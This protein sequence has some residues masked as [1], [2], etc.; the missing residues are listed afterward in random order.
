[1][2]KYLYILNILNMKYGGE[3]IALNKIKRLESYLSEGLPRY[4]DILEQ[5]NK[6]MPETP[7]GIEY[8]SPGIMESQIFTV[9]TKRFKSGRL[10]FSKFGATCLAKIC[11]IKVQEGVIEIENIEEEV[12]VDNSIEEYMNEVKKA[13]KQTQK[14]LI[15]LKNG[16][17][18]EKYNNVYI[19]PQN[20][21]YQALKQTPI[22]ELEYII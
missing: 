21:I 20:P 4:Q 1:M 11:A 12:Q 6:T 2:M 5:K 13:V 9:L 14:A 15:K 7:E 19:N 10:S 3:E 17:D 22:S 18:I 8:R 16:E